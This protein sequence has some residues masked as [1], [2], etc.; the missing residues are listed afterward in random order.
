MCRRYTQKHRKVDVRA[1]K[2][3]CR[4]ILE[5]LQYLHC[6][7][8][9]VI[10]RDVKPDHLF[11]KGNTGEV[12]LGGLS[13]ARTMGAHRMA[14]TCVGARPEHPAAPKEHRTLQTQAWAFTCYAHPRAARPLTCHDQCAR[15][16]RIHGA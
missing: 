13:L 11:I 14:H 16:A 15:H 7:Q 10:H 5:G 6:L 8:P 1:L 4:Q 9:L 2:N 3:W 12:K